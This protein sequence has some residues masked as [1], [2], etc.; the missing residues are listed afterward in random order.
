MGDNNIYL[1]YLT[2]LPN[3]Y[4]LYNFFKKNI[5][6]FIVLL[7]GIDDF[8][9][10]N[11]TVGILYGD[12]F[13]NAISNRLLKLIGK[14]GMVFKHIGDEFLILLPKSD[15]RHID[16]KIYLILERFKGGI[17]VEDLEIVVSASI[18]IYIPKDC[19]SIDD[20]IRKAEVAMHEAKR[21]SKG[22]YIYFDEHIEEKIKRK[23]AISKE[24]RKSIKREELYLLYQPIFDIKENKILE[25]EVLLR[26]KNKE[27]G[28]VSPAEFIPIAEETG[29]IRE[30]GLWVIKKVCNQMKKWEK[31][32]VNPKV[33]I[34]ISPY[35]FEDRN[36]FN[37]LKNII[38]NEGIDFNKIKFEIT[39][40]QIL[41][42]EKQ[43]IRNLIELTKLGTSI[44]L[45][46]FG[47]GYSSLKNLTF[48]PITEIKIDKSFIDY[49]YKDEKIQKLIF[50]IIL[51]A[52]NLGYKVTAEGVESKEQL[53]KLL[54]YGCDKIQGFYIS[55]PISEKDIVEFV[56]ENI[57]KVS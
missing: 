44:S 30:L 18:G 40:T 46:D 55:K 9:Y 1:D 16:E 23:A 25:V 13:L 27:L 10:I 14:E 54:E 4:F 6:E 5:N 22:Q 35:Q 32:N 29:F 19:D 20:A 41:K 8:K 33:A 2:G 38:K 57:I 48:F 45:D 53:D 39:E 47:V 17:E 28:E 12:K 7:L 49:L 51:M 3:K 15:M 56:N 52:H 36:F 26:W 24:L 43:N 37:N 50:L 34:N 11:D 42:S 21:K 31:K